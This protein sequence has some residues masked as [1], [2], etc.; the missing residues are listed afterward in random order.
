M[1]AWLLKEQTGLSGLSLVEV[2]DPKPKSNEVVL[3]VRYAGLNPA[4]RYL[5]EKQYPAK[6]QLP[7]I[8]GR[9]GLGTVLEVGDGVRNVQPGAV[10]AIA[11]GEVGVNSPG[12]FA[13]RVAVPI[14]DLIMPPEGWTAPEAGGAILVY[15]T[16]YQALTMWG[17]LPERPVVLVTGASGGVGVAT[18]QLAA[19]MGY[20]VIALS[21]SSE[22]RRRLLELGAKFTPNPED[23]QWRTQV[24]TELNPGRVDLAVDNVGGKLFS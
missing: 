12:T 2:P 3:K 10:R 20:T 15:L 9:D 14:E 18:V 23:P 16:A 22:K 21:R 19:A 24:K 11:R 1:R 4:D 17:L 6:P 7:H 5:A 13:E 8:L